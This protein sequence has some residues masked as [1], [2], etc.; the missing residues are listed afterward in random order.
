MP[1]AQQ[2]STTA[3]PKRILL[4]EDDLHVAETLA[5]LLELDG[6]QVCV[7]HDALT[8]LHQLARQPVDLVLCDLTLR[9]DMDGFGFAAAC[10]A[11]PML[12]LLHLLAVSGYDRPED[13]RRAQA[14]GFDDL[15]GKPVD[16][17][18]I[19][20]AIDEGRRAC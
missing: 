13:R 9:G 10:R 2:F 6:Y 11:D 15:V 7:A 4:V 5:E 16:L 17:E 18:R 14:A 12:R 1:A 3:G 8:G 19:H 20:A